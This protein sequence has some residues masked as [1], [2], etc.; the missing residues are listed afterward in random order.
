MNTR[1]TLAQQIGLMLIANVEQAT[2]IESLR[3]QVAKL[4]EELA[5][6]NRR[7]AEMTRES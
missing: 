1:D 3:E 4:T 6:A 5:E 2:T 7:L